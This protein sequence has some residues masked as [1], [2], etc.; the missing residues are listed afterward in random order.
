MGILDVNS[1]GKE[2]GTNVVKSSGEREEETGGQWC[3]RGL[4]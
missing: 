2:A 1:G 3:E 4:E